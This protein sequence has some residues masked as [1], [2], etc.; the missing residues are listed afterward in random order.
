M[1]YNSM[2]HHQQIII[3]SSCKKI[4]IAFHDLVY[5]VHAHELQYSL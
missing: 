2:D 3:L 4:N 1:T 5:H